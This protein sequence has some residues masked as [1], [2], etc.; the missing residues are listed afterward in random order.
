MLASLPARLDDDQLALVERVAAVPVPALPPADPEHLDRCLAALDASLPRQADGEVSGSLRLSVYRK[1]LKH[2]PK[3]AVS[4]LYQEAVRKCRWFPT[5]AECLAIAGEWRRGDEPVQA[6]AKAEALA[7]RER[8]LRMD[9]A[10]G[11]LQRGE[12]DDEAVNAWP[13]WWKLIAQ[14]RGLI[15]IADGECRI[16]PSAI[17]RPEVQVAPAEMMER[18]AEQFPSERGAA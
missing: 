9:E 14:T 8:E 7:R 3:A 15:R 13:E 5:I 2:L 16:R 4:F 11:A 10:M 18:A 12:L 6:R 1:E 17:W